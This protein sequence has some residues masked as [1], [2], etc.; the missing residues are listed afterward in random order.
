M[1]G[2][3]ANFSISFGGSVLTVEASRVSVSSA[4]VY[5]NSGEE[6]FYRRQCVR[7]NGRF[8]LV[9]CALVKRRVFHFGQ[10]LIAKLKDIEV[11]RLR[12]DD[13]LQKA[14]SDQMVSQNLWQKIVRV[15][16]A[17]FACSEKQR[18]KNLTES[19]MPGN[20]GNFE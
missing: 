13:D 16:Q 3:S 1:T 15:I 4:P 18:A 2:T 11:L 17:H 19:G 9:G 14:I 5:L 6:L 20:G 8:L 12:I 7:N 10:Q